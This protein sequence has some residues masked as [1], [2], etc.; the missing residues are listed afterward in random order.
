MEN[1]DD[2]GVFSARQDFSRLRE[3]MIEAERQAVLDARKE[4]RYQEPAVRAALADVDLQETL[5]HTRRPAAPGE[6]LT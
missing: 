2:S 4:G 1:S 6:N 3:E 5:I